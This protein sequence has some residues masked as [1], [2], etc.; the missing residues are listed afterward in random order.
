MSATSPPSDGPPTNGAA[1]K[2]VPTWG[3]IV[4]LVWFVALSAA[5]VYG[6]VELWPPG[7]QTSTG[8]ANG[9][10]PS[11]SPSVKPSAT[12]TPTRSVNPIPSPSPSPSVNP[13][14]TPSSTPSPTPQQSLA[15]GSAPSG[16]VSTGAVSSSSPGQATGATTTSAQGSGANNSQDAQPA[17]ETGIFASLRNRGDDT[18]LLFLVL[19][20]GA[21]GAMVSVFRSFTWY[22]GHGK[23]FAHWVPYYLLRP[24]VGATLAIVFFLVIHGG[25]AQ[26]MAQSN[27]FGYVALAA[28]IGLFS[29]QAAEKLKEIAE[30][31]FK[32]APKG[33]GTV[34]TVAS[35]SPHSGPQGG[36][37]PVT[38]TGTGFVKGATVSFGKQ[39]ATTGDPSADGTTI[40]ATA[41]AAT[42]PGPVDVT[43]KNP[44]G[45]AAVLPG[46]FTYLP[47]SPP[48]SSPPGSSPP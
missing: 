8:Q 16:T 40:T 15:Q 1:A 46:G 12:P 29:E 18:R 11:P 32:P 13:G 27:A 33:A 45:H 44:D 43:V 31:V 48:P 34:P 9:G 10:T 14:A 26:D 42:Q 7:P 30:T 41:P 19:L 25:F 47:S 38:I 28:I 2:L 24:F 6:L 3:I 20:A 37:T 36:H 5:L 21:L 23:L 39:A 17:S 4:L 22:V 35:I